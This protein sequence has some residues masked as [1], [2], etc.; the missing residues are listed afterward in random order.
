MLLFGFYKIFQRFKTKDFNQ[1]IN[2]GRQT[3][4]SFKILKR[5]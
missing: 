1:L 5:S 3:E 2:I 4:E